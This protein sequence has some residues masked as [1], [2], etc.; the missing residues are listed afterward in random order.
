MEIAQL[1]VSTQRH[2]D[3][4]Q[5]TAKVNH[6]HYGKASKKSKT[7][8]DPVA[9]VVAV[10]VIVAAE[11]TLETLE[12]LQE[13]AGKFHYQMTSVGD[14]GKADIRRDN[15]VKLWKPSVETVEQRDTTRR[16]V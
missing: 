1:E 10:V 4:M 11:S 2:I 12:N 3:R 8:P 6:M 13:R 14:V 7:T 5:E 15:L 16:C 9:A